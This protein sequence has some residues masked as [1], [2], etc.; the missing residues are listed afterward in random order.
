M[1]KRILF[2]RS[3]GGMPGIDIHAGMWAAL[4]QFGI[5][6]TDCSGTSAGAIVSALDATGCSAS[7][8]ISIVRNLND[9]DVRQDVPMWKFRIPWLNHFIRNEPIREVL[10]N[11]LS[12]VPRPALD[13]GLQ[14]W[15]QD[16]AS[17]Q[18]CD[19]MTFTEA[20]LVDAVLA[21]MSISG[22][23]PPVKIGSDTFVDG[24]GAH[25][26][27]VPKDL[28]PYDEIW[29]LVAT[30]NP[31][32]YLKTTGILTHLLRNI[33]FLIQGQMM[34]SIDDAQRWSS[35]FKKIR[36]LWPA[37]HRRG[38]SFHFDHGLIDESFLWTKTKLQE[39]R[40]GGLL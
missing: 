25:N 36:L 1:T 2:V 24:F 21:S 28:T 33:E 20:S 32:D 15:A 11:L 8:A 14:I 17:A 10:V 38:S 6:S 39:L 9:D 18:A 19:L 7:R 40:D 29:L 4:E 27:P 3:G 26:L 23:F 37:V 22:V 12:D 5:C 31:K 35:P 34:E 13:K 16:Q 30:G